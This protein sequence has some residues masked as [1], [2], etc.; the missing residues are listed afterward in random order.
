MPED[1]RKEKDDV[2]GDGD[3]LE[4]DLPR[5]HPPVL[6]ENHSKEQPSHSPGYVTAVG[7]AVGG[8]LCDV[9][10]CHPDIIRSVADYEGKSDASVG[11]IL[12]STFFGYKESPDER[13][14]RQRDGFV[15]VLPSS[16]DHPVLPPVE[17]QA[18]EVGGDEGIDP[19]RGSNK[20]PGWIREESTQD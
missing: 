16:E 5:H 12:L 14:E 17:D 10:D 1:P 4:V 8:I 11:E 7:D 15:V 9:E 13:I 2:E 6:Q 19:G 18:G 20:A 3:S